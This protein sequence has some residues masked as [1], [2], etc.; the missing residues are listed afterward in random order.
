MSAQPA[1]PNTSTELLEALSALLG[2]RVRGV[3]CD[4]PAREAGRRRGWLFSVGEAE[5]A[6]AIYLESS[7]SLREPSRLNSW[8][9]QAVNWRRPPGRAWAEL[10][11]LGL[12]DARTVARLAHEVIEAV[13]A[14]RGAR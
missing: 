8:R 6:R 12:A 4:P 14:E 2:L 13:A 9:A 1:Q 10:P 5:E 11:P 7:D 3:R